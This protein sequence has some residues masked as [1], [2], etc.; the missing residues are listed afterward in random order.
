MSITI[1][2]STKQE[3]TIY[4]NN[5]SLGNIK[6]YNNSFHTQNCYLQLNLNSYDPIIAAELFKLLSRDINR[7]LQ[8]MSASDEEELITFLEN[9]GFKCKRRCYEMEVS[10]ENYI[11]EAHKKMN[12]QY[13]IQ[14]S[15]EYDKCCL[16]MY[17]YYSRIHE[18]VNPLTADYSTFTERL[19]KQAFYQYENEKAANVAFVE[20]NEIAYVASSKLGDFKDFIRSVVEAMFEKYENICFECDDCDE[21]AMELFTIFESDTD[22]SY[23]TYIR[24]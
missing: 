13:C 20:E 3:Y 8:V 12:F 16:L 18:S 7:P 17:H 4:N 24:A 19:P 10:P 9:G 21:A 23:N 14:G 11:A 6:L 22:D 1:N 2:K 15:A 5:Q